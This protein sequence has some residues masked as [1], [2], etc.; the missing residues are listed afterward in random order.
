MLANMFKKKN[1]R[2]V[3]K[4]VKMNEEKAQDANVEDNSVLLDAA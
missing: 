4:N 2:L 1:E 3:I